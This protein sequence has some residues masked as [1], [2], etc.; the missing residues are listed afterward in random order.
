MIKRI[1]DPVD[2]VTPVSNRIEQDVD[3]I[4]PWAFAIVRKHGCVVHGTTPRT[5]SRWVAA[6]HEVGTEVTNQ[7]R[8][9]GGTWVTGCYKMMVLHKD[10]MQVETKL[11]ASFVTQNPVPAVIGAVEHVESIDYTGSAISGDAPVD[12]ALGDTNNTYEL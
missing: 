4:I 11:I 6:Q 2:G 12:L 10:A 5:G 1:C 3:R 8:N 9:K 7:T